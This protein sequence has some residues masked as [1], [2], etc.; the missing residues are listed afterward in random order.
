VELQFQ[1]RF[2]QNAFKLLAALKGE[3]PEDYRQFALRVRPFERGSKGYFKGNLFPAACNNLG[4]WG[5]DHREETGFSDKVSYQ[6]WMRKTRFAIV[7]AWIEKCRPKLLICTGL[8]HI[9]DFLTLTDTKEVPAPYVFHV[10]GHPKRIHVTS[11]GIVP[12]AVIPHLSGG[13]H[14]LNS[15][16]S[17]SETAA[18]I[19]RTLPGIAF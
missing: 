14:S 1:F 15:S 17:I 11:T 9:D 7:K 10:N 8:T 19:R 18:H 5:E 12:L 3:S 2:N 13:A 4:E 6:D 16:E